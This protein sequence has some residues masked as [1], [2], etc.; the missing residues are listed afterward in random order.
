MTPF[1]VSFEESK[2]DYEALR[3]ITLICK[4]K[5]FLI[6]K[7]VLI[8]PIM[9]DKE[10]PTY[11]KELIEFRLIRWLHTH[12]FYYSE[13]TRFQKLLLFFKPLKT[14]PGAR[15]KYLFNKMYIYELTEKSN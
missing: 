8:N 7:S 3:G 12:V 6:R 2:S 11:Q 4:I 9:P 15:F 10:I 1:E 13:A 5:N 14:E